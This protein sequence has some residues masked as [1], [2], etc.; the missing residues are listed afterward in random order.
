MQG[1][2][3]ACDASAALLG[4]FAAGWEGPR[5]GPM[6]DLFFVKRAS[7]LGTEDEI[8]DVADHV[9]KRQVRVHQSQVQKRS[10]GES[11]CP[12]AEAILARD[13]SLRLLVQRV[14]GSRRPLMN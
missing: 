1:H 10:P 5:L 2:A 3:Q 14:E 11:S 12:P 4:A 13:V 7:W 9:G 8:L 6:T